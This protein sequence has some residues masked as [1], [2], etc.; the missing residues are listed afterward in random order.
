MGGVYVWLSM[1]CSLTK[2]ASFSSPAC[3]SL[4]ASKNSLDTYFLTN[5]QII[6]HLRA[7]VLSACNYTFVRFWLYI[8]ETLPVF[9]ITHLWWKE[10]WFYA[11][12][13][14]NVYNAV[15]CNSRK[16]DLSNLISSG[17]KKLCQ[18]HIEKAVGCGMWCASFPSYSCTRVFAQRE[19]PESWRAG[20]GTP[21]RSPR[22]S[23]T[24]FWYFHV[25]NK[26]NPR[27]TQTADKASLSPC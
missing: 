1:L 6:Q 23:V 7:I 14:P 16:R 8:L 4:C 5:S 11:Y 17:H 20:T 24:T 3:S 21:M 25:P 15:S 10:Q 2:W 18:N 12:Y 27:T 19:A 13:G 9:I 26:P 22:T